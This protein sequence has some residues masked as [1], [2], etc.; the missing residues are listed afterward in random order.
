MPRTSPTS[1]A[2]TEATQ[3]T[4]AGRLAEATA[5]IRQNLG[6]AT[7]VPQPEQQPADGRLARLRTAARRLVTAAPEAPAGG[8]SA[9]AGRFLQRTHTGPAGER[10]YRLYVP[11]GYDGRDVP[12][13]VLLHGG[14]QSAEDFA[15]GTRMNELA[16]RDTFLVAYPQQ[17]RAANS[18]GYWNWFQ[19]TDQQRD[20]GEPSLIAGITRDVLRDHAVDDDRVYVAGLSAGGAMAAVMAA[21]YPDLYAAAGV[22]SGIAYGVASDLPS[23]FAV[24][25]SGGTLPRRQSLEAIP[26][27]VFHGDQ[28]TTVSPV[29][30]DRLVE[31]GLPRGRSARAGQASRHE[32]DGNGGHAYTRTAYSDGRGGVALE[33]WLVHG[34]GH[35]WSGGSP[36]GSYTDPQG[37]D[38]SAELVRFFREHPRG[39]HS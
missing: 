16:E 33:R 34:A 21:T 39:R 8:A 19:P 31:S 30:A 23:A 25:R 27:I 3:L 22:H 15:R 17:S 10:T 13:V 5:L 14:T 20:A 37:P 18:M 7:A 4:R 1:A 12:L 26:M 35:A 32:A 11:S 38:A 9:P 2:M 6:G 28:D 36:Q 29:N 24:M